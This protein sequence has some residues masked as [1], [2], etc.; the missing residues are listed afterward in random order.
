[1]SGSLTCQREKQR[2]LERAR[3]AHLGFSRFYGE[4][5]NKRNTH[6]WQE[7]CVKMSPVYARIRTRARG[8][9]LSGVEIIVAILQLEEESTAFTV[10][11][12]SI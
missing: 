2:I 6:T 11:A 5:D 1:M 8:F 12:A 3:G 7:L 4:R 10:K 9:G